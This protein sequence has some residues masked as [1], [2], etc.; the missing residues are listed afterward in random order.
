MS[1]A[2]KA[3]IRADLTV[4]TEDGDIFSVYTQDRGNMYVPLGYAHARARQH[5]HKVAAPVKDTSHSVSVFAGHLRPEQER[6][7]TALVSSLEE[8][9]VGLVSAHCGFGKTIT[10]LA[11]AC[12][13]GVRRVLIAVNSLILTRQWE[14]AVQEFVPSAKF[15]SLK[16]TDRRV[17][18]DA[19]FLIVNVTNLNK[20]GRNMF[21]GKVDMLV[22]D[23][24]HQMVSPQ[25]FL[26]LMMIEPRYVVGLSATPHRYDCFHALIE[27]FF[28]SVRIEVHR[29]TPFHVYTIDT[30][31]CPLVQLMY[32]GRI[33]WNTV[34]QSQAVSEPRNRLI[35]DTVCRFPE[36]IWLIF[37]KRVQHIDLL[38][39]MFDERGV[40]VETLAGTKSDFDRSARVIIG[41][42]QKIGV[43]FDHQPV[44]A[45]L[46][47][48]D[49]QNYVRQYI[50]RC[51]RVPDVTPMVVDL[52]DNFGVLRMHH[53]KRCVVYR[54]MGA[55]VKPMGII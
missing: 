26:G 45:L 20:M 4:A 15:Q 39:R 46:F 31:F 7:A 29:H 1:L 47:A 23:E 37:V 12:R 10:S 32:N 41:T 21:R 35:V 14:E 36:R 53:A 5:G 51:L 48:A 33:N 22:V 6:V 52:V 18:S 25:R 28:G 54:D 43:G 9:R 50:G 38:V 44:D 16:P 34:L 17:D 8:H 13:M 3:S 2:D 27:W 55:V 30:H 11:A 19:T 24:L 42:I 40:R 49:V